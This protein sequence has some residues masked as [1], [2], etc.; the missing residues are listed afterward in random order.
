MIHRIC[1]V[2]GGTGGH[3]VPAIAFG[4]WLKTKHPL[5]DIDFISGSRK[6]EKEIYYAHKIS[7]TICPISGSPYG[8]KNF[9]V[10]ILRWKEILFS[11]FYALYYINKKNPDVILLFGGYVSLPFLLAGKF[12]K[13]KIFMHEQN[14]KRG[15]VSRLASRLG[16]E[17]LDSWNAN[18]SSQCIC[19]GMPLRKLEHVQ[20]SV[21]LEK[22]GLSKISPGSCVL[23]VLGGSLG[24]P[25]LVE[26]ISHISQDPFFK[27]WEFVVLGEKSGYICQ[28]VH[29]VES[30]WNPSL[31][32]SILDLALTRA[33]GS[34]LAELV[35]Y[36][37]PALILPLKKSSEGHQ[38]EN[39]KYFSELGLGMVSE[40]DIVEVKDSLKLIFKK[41]K[42]KEIDF[43]KCVDHTL[44]CKKI[45]D[46]VI[47]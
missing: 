3:I 2:A 18:G 15:K 24:S 39:A 23:G 14:V 8:V 36:R 22:L 41:N 6:I 43:E 35:S 45:Y 1:L 38:V 44:S 29:I 30:S 32:Y 11:V 4:Q 9:F 42:N 7:A 25:E 27:S 33:G 12:K 13:K 17:I 16:V 5:I 19:V 26:Y 31:L 10:K 47:K 20:R 37:I 21:A 46:L 34:T 40:D 28:N